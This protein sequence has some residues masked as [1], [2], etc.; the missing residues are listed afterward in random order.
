MN[1]LKL[2]AA[3]APGT[4]M[5]QASLLLQYGRAPPAIDVANT[6]YKADQ[7]PG[8][9][10]PSSVTPDWKELPPFWCRGAGAAP[11]SL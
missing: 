6:L 11:I 3:P 8:G 5:V 9:G 4:T 2:G 10:G 7:L 1:P